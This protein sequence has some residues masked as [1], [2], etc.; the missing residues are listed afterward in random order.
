MTP[1]LIFTQFGD[2]ASAL[3]PQR[4]FQ[5]LMLVCPK[6]K[7][8]VIIYSDRPILVPF[9]ENID[10]SELVSWLD[11]NDE[12]YGYHASNY[13]RMW[14][15]LQASGEAVYL[16][17]DMKVV[18]PSFVE[19]FQLAKKFGICLPQSNRWVVREDLRIGVEVS[20]QDRRD[21]RS[22]IYGTLWNASPIFIVPQHEVALRFVDVF[23]QEYRN[24]PRR[25]PLGMWRAAWKS[26]VSPFT[27]PVQW[28]LPS[29]LQYLPYHIVHHG[30]WG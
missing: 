12:R 14:A 24:N 27:L 29:E 21:M 16:D 26:G 28:C 23:L 1:T 13:I 2:R 8:R 7:P 25:G 22:P 18:S 4:V 3:E 17:G 11:S 15:L 19:G 20:K 30:F 10:V 6:L 5:Q 9:A